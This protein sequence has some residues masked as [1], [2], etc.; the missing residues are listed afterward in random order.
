MCQCAER[1]AAISVAA[2][3]MAHRDFA[4]VRREAAFVGRSFVDDLRHDPA[5]LAASARQALLAA[6]RGRLAR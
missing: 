2:R 4:T 6:A 1:R 3:A 5:G